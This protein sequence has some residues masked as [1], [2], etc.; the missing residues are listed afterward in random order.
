MSVNTEP[1]ARLN[2][3]QELVLPLEVLDV[4]EDG[5]ETGHD[6]TGETLTLKVFQLEEEKFT[7]S[8]GSGIVHDPDQVTNPGKA[9]A[10]LPGGATVNLVPEQPH[11][12][13]LVLTD[14]LGKP[15]VIA[16]D[17]V[18]EVDWPAIA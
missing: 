13:V 4:D 3:G 14:S 16:K 5:V 8:T 17:L 11:Q 9:T 15:V 2:P 7:V 12:M 10:T 18:L 6:L 1:D